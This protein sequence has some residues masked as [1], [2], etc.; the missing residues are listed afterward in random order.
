MSIFQLAPLNA[1]IKPRLQLT[2]AQLSLIL[3]LE[4][5]LRDAG[6]GLICPF[7]AGSAPCDGLLTAGNHPLDLVWKLDCDCVERR[8]MHGGVSPVPPSGDLILLAAEALKDARLDIRCLRTQTQCRYHPLVSQ[9]LPTQIR[10]RCHCGEMTFKA[11]RT[12]AKPS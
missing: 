9:R 7:C 3:G 12:A 1:P 5:V 6:L 11:A 8:G 10:M 2:K 4:S